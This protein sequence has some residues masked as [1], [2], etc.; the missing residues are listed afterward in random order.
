MY[1]D[2]DSLRLATLLLANRVLLPT[3]W[4]S[5][6]LNRRVSDE[7]CVVSDSFRGKDPDLVNLNQIIPLPVS[8]I[9]RPWEQNNPLTVKF[10]G[11]EDKQVRG[12]ATSITKI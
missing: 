5:C 12:T 10:L 9:S 6:L 2:A 1:L 11:R 8:K 3:L 7:Q 4:L